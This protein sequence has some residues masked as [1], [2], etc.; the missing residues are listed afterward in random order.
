MG[1]GRSE[2]RCGMDYISHNILDFPHFFNVSSSLSAH[3]SL[4]L[5]SSLSLAGKDIGSLIC[6]VGS[7]AAAAAAAPASGGGGGGGGE[8]EERQQLKRRRKKKKRKNL[9]MI[10]GLVSW[11]E[12]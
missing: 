6:N 8:R 12:R 3:S 2:F 5:A 9:M 1:V 4:P 10:W 7:G 11:V